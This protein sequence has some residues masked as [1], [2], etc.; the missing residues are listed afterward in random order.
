MRRVAN[1]P[2]PYHSTIVEWT[3]E[4]PEAELEIYE[5]TE[6]RSIITRNQSPDVG[7]EYS[8][9]PYRGCTHAC[10]YCFARPYHEYLG[11]G[12]GTDFERKIV[13]K[14]RAPEILRR[15]LMRP[16]WQGAPLAFSFTSDPYL[17]LENHYRLT[18][19]C[20]EVCLEF[21]Q[22]VEIVT[23]SALVRRDVEL[24]VE[25]SRQAS[26]GVYFSIPFA[27]D[28]TARALEPFAP[29]PSARF[30]AMR[31]LAEAGISVSIG[32]APMIPGLNDSDIPQLL[33]QAH[34]AGARAAWMTMLRLPGSVAPYFVERLRERL[35]LKAERVLNHIREERG[36]GLNSAD[37]GARMKGTSEQWKM[38]EQL[39][40]LYCRRLGFNR[41]NSQ[42]TENTFRRPSLQPTLFD[43]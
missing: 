9:N 24:L 26:C 15:E 22:P 4:P 35:P 3:E 37:F 17:P 12:A 14:V 6:T 38:I 30:R 40:R 20:L 33:K 1:P 36:G 13:V 5:E 11:F 2:N 43:E 23:K 27:D 25:L 34:E 10:T 39:F 42:P 21:R 41:E 29:S 31:E 7:F 16:N 18:M 28:E 19:Q 32:L 8:V